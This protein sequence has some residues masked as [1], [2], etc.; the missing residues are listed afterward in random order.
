MPK[1]FKKQVSYK[2]Q[3]RRNGEKLIEQVQ[4]YSCYQI[5]NKKSCTIA[6]TLFINTNIN[7]LA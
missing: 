2:L 6:R 4:K 1:I 5:N 7:P 3:N